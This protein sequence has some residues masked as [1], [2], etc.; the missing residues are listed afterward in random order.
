[1]EDTFKPGI[2]TIFAK[3]YCSGKL[4]DCPE[5]NDLKKDDPESYKSTEKFAKKL[6][7]LGLLERKEIQDLSKKYDYNVWLWLD[8]VQVIVRRFDNPKTGKSEY[9][10]G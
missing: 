8:W 4:S 3:Y 2:V 5:N 1:M 9:D 7:K 6:T 10:Y